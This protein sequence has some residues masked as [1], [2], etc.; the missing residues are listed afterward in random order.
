[1]VM[2]GYKSMFS[3]SMKKKKWMNENLEN[4]KK[5]DK[6]NVFIQFLFFKRKVFLLWDWMKNNRRE[7]KIGYEK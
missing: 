1:M 5:D 7:K 3:C 6:G 4:L 2:I